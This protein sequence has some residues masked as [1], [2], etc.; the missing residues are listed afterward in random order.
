MTALV[1]GGGV[2]VGCSEWVAHLGVS[3]YPTFFSDTLVTINNGTTFRVPPYP[4]R[5]K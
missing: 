1:T 5:C 4:M 3:R 2:T